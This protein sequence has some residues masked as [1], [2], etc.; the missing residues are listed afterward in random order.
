MP[1]FIIIIIM[2]YSLISLYIPNQG[3]G[4]QYNIITLSVS[5]KR[6]KRSLFSENI[7]YDLVII[8]VFGLINNDGRPH[9]VNNNL[10]KILQ[11]IL[12]FN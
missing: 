12:S 11:N 7:V 10:F 2:F 8:L 3:E 4:I 9:R 1:A 5:S 6:K